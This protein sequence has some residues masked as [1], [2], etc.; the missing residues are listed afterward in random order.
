[1]PHRISRREVI[2]G[3][4]AALAAAAL[5]PSVARASTPRDLPDPTP[6]P[7]VLGPT[8]PPKGLAAVNAVLSGT[9][10][11]IG[12]DW[13]DWSEDAR[14]YAMATVKS[15]GYNFITPKV[16]G[17]GRTWYRDEDHLRRWYDAAKGI[18]LAFAPFIYCTPDS[19]VAD[20][21]IS[22][23]IA[24]VC[25]IANLDLEDE[26][27]P[28]EKGATPG[29]RGAAMAELG[30]VYRAEAGDLPIIA[31]GYGD[32]ITRFGPAG[33]GFPNAEVAEWADVYSPQWYIGV[34]SRYHKGGVKAAL[35]WGED[36][37]HQAMGP[38]F[39]ICP[40]V[41]LNCSYTPDHLLPLNDTKAMMDRLR[42]TYNAPIF[43][44][45]YMVITP[46]HT[47]ALLGAPKIANVRLGKIQATSFSVVWDTN[48]PAL[49]TLT[50]K[51]PGDASPKT[52]QSDRLALT[53]SEG[54]SK[55]EPGTNCLVT[56][57]STTGGGASATVPL[58][59]A[60]APSAGGVFVQSAQA[61][62]DAQG[63]V[64]VTLLIGNSG[65]DD[66]KDVTVTSLSADGGDLISPK[67]LPY[68]IGPLAHRDWSGSTFDRAEMSV[69]LTNIVPL[70]TTLTL[71]VAGT[72]DSGA[73][74]KSDIPV[75][76][77]A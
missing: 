63:H 54:I 26:W 5:L 28:N 35:D 50:S 10:V 42:A 57:Q 37:V 17:Y 40:S 45:Q 31:N 39:P 74:W 8:Q 33:T 60:T 2:Q 77:P 61:A 14:L 22:A 47:Q 53:H 16:G 12:N 41:D 64:V 6:P 46:Q 72:T 51:A 34:Y 55:L 62:R 76:L 43:V 7:P 70:T 15:W 48:I 24:R 49:S 3:G 52:S 23:Q 27:G 59:V 44:W 25:G 66:V 13:F 58:T 68:D 75:G 11:Y 1:M 29:Y 21:R 65:R 4:A 73:A 56:V 30:R 20:A 69:V 19:R 71:H 18:G 38:N 36:E 67:L 9:G 32:P